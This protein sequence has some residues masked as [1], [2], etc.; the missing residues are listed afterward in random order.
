MIPEEQVGT[1]RAHWYWSVIC[2]RLFWWKIR[3]W[4]CIYAYML[5]TMKSVL[6]ISL[7]NYRGHTAFTHFQIYGFLAGLRNRTPVISILLSA[8]NLSL[9]LGSNTSQGWLLCWLKPAL[10][11]VAYFTQRCLPYLSLHQGMLTV[12]ERR[13]ARREED[14]MM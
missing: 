13:E 3:K 4:I 11:R 14:R 2:P 6:T 12:E 5:I 9:M 1:R 7:Q 8:A 10:P